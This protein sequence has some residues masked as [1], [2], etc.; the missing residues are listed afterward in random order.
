MKNPEILRRE[1]ADANV[2][3]L[4]AA[5]DALRLM[6]AQAAYPQPYGLAATSGMGN[7]REAQ[8]Q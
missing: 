6:I 8:R 2:F 7:G 1:I 4:L 3:A 5:S